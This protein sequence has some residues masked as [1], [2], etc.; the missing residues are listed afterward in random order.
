LSLE[1]EDPF[2]VIGKEM[3]SIKL[4]GRG[5]ESGVERRIDGS[6]DCRGTSSQL[7]RGRQGGGK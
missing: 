7:P 1:V 3:N 4:G 6:I 5:L 2:K